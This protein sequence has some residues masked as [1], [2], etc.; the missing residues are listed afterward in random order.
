MALSKIKIKI[1]QEIGQTLK[2]LKERIIQAG[3]NIDEICAKIN[4]NRLQ[5]DVWTIIHC[6]PAMGED[7]LI[8]V[9]TIIEGEDYILEVKL[10]ALTK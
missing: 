2:G 8:L 6:Y 9:L 10:S 1:I 7:D 3:D 5:G 4:A